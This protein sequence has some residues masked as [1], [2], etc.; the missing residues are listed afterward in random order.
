MIR[1]FYLAGLV[2]SASLHNGAAACT[3]G[4][5][6]GAEAVKTGEGG[7]PGSFQGRQFW[8]SVGRNR[9]RDCRC[10]CRGDIGKPE[11]HRVV[12]NQPDQSQDT[13]CGLHK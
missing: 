7:E 9:Y 4:V 13:G 12:A 1:V 6:S 8:L 10:V 3:L 2:W 11:R 5:G